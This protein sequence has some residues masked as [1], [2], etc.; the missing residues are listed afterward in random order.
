MVAERALRTCVNARPD[1]PCDNRAVV[2]SLDGVSDLPHC[3]TDAAFQVPPLPGIGRVHPG[4][5]TYE[6]ADSSALGLASS[7]LRHRSDARAKYSKAF[8][9]SS[10]RPCV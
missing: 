5:L 4:L 3:F 6:V 8:W 2:P 10:F 9:N 7:I 1:Y